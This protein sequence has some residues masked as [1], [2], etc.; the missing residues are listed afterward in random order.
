MS[1]APPSSGVSGSKTAAKTVLAGPASKSYNVAS[2]WEQ[3]A[4]LSEDELRVVEHLSQSCSGRAYP[5]HV[6]EDQRYTVESTHIQGKDSYIGT[7]EDAVLHNT[8]QFHKW[9]SELEAACA[10]ETEEKYQKYANL[11]NSQ[12]AA[13]ETIL[14]KVEQTLELFDQLLA[15]HKEVSQ[16][17]KALFSSCE[18]L[19][20]EKDQLLEFA[21]AL[22][23]KLKFFDEF[24]TVYTQFHAA[25]SSLDNEQ[26]LQLLKKLD[27]CIAYVAKNPQYA[28][29]ATYINKF[30]QLQGRALGTVKTKVQQVLKQAIQQVMSA[31]QEAAQ[32]GNNST[33]KGKGSQGTLPVLAEGS[34]VPMLYVRFRAAAEPNLKG[35]FR[36][37]ESRA[38][39]PEYVRLL[40]ECQTVY[41]QARLQ[42]V[43]PFVQQRIQD[44]TSQPLPLFT[45]NGCEHL[46]RVCQLELQLFEQFFPKSKDHPDMLAPLMDPLCVILYDVLR[47]LIIQLQD[48]DDLC[49]LIDILKHEVL[50]EQLLKRGSGV[51]ALR[52]TLSRCLADV[53]ERLIYRCQAFIKD[54]VGSFVP[55]PD[56][57][58][59]CTKLEQLPG[60]ETASNGAAAD[61]NNDHGAS[62]GETRNGDAGHGASSSTAAAQHIQGHT[63]VYKPL[64]HTLL[65]LSKLYRA[66]DSKTFGGLAQE[67]VSACTLSIQQASRLVAR[68]HGP[69]DAQLFMIK[70]L[71]FLR[72]Q[73]APFDVD[74]ATWDVDLDFTHMR[75]HLRRILA[76]ESSLFTFSASN[77][78]V[79]ML[80]KGGPRV[81]Q[82][83]VDSKKDLEKQLKMVCESFIMAVTKIAVEPMLSFIT[84]VTAVR[85]SERANPAG[86]KKLREQAF[87]AAPKLAEIVN[88]VNQELTNTLPVTF[89]KMKMYLTNPSTHGILFKPVKSNIAEAHGQ[90]AQLLEHEYSPE[91]AATVPLMQPQQLGQLLDSF[92]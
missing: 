70:H 32:T 41:A 13:C 24:E 77:A 25:Q 22:R 50:G 63:Q 78:V 74:F 66:V 42:L 39:R 88:K 72:E 35:L 37:V 34:E 62:N 19:V 89:N 68:K 12:L 14:D 64:R 84:K 55:T 27:E 75:D 86:P 76:G 8:N 6:S 83:Q 43:S 9:Y 85:V 69:L 49:E 81:L 52:P 29:S 10:S 48:M 40:T 87:A 1:S 60:P 38:N 45:R 79:Q 91:E 16:K 18:Q 65:C 54:E 2:V 21:D 26:F 44:Y 47:P 59:S 57:I 82:F 56:D 67:A 51:E 73:I 28:D 7:L 30:R 90:I 92:C 61:G 58:E 53:Q 5:S 23:A 33:I 11:L 31:V 20:K 36:E 17:S 46:M 3:T 15:Q 4:A 80:G 71:L